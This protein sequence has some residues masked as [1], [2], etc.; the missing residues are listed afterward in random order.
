MV[1]AACGSYY[2]VRGLADTHRQVVHTHEVLTAVRQTLSLLKDAETGQRG[3][4][5]TGDPRYL[6]P[7]RAADGQVRGEVE[8]LRRLTADNPAQQ[9]RLAEP[10]ETIALRR[11]AGFEAARRVV[12]EDRGKKLMDEVRRLTGEME[13]E[14]QGLLERRAAVADGR[15]RRSAGTVVLLA[16]FALL[17]VVI[18]RSGSTGPAR[19]P[20]PP[21]DS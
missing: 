2:G 3:Y 4:L 12:V 15:V 11:D 9:G 5:L 6:E 10:D 7:Y 8:R 14:E 18:G 20:E 1:A 19:P 17:A 16:A 21:D 13:A